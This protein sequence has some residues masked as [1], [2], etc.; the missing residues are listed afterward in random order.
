MGAT[1]AANPR[2]GQCGQAERVELGVRRQG[3][4][5]IGGWHISSRSGEGY[6]IVAKMMCV[7]LCSTCIYNFTNPLSAR[8]QTPSTHTCTYTRT[9]TRYRY[10]LTN[11]F[12]ERFKANTE[13]RFDTQHADAA[14][15]APSQMTPTKKRRGQGFKKTSRALDEEE[16][17]ASIAA[18]RRGVLKPLVRA[19]YVSLVNIHI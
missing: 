19:W 13:F 11:G 18:Q 12:P 3:S 17:E 16:L 2:R 6:T 9:R 4:A 10:K 14:P 7:L 1:A 8:T 15:A 5:R